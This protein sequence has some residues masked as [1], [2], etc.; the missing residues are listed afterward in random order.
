MNW[1]KL[2]TI[3]AWT[4]GLTAI[5][6]AFFKKYLHNYFW[7]LFPIEV[8][9]VLLYIISEIVRFWIKFKLKHKK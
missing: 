6:Y 1:Q 3:G 5:F 9:S 2:S 7:I 8:A 4:A